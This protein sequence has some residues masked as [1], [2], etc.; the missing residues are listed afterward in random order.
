MR[1]KPI[2]RYCGSDDV[3]ADARLISAAPDMLDALEAL[4]EEMEETGAYQDML[5]GHD[6]FLAVAVEKARSAID[7]AKGN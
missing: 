5:A 4:L 2:C 1:T 7:K 6:P 3:C